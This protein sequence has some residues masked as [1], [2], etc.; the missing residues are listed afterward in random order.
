MEII[1][2]AFVMTVLFTGGSFAVLYFIFYVASNWAKNC[3]LHLF[4]RKKIFEEGAFEYYECPK[5]KIREALHR[6]GYSPLN[7][8]WLN[9]G[10]RE[11]STNGTVDEPLPPQPPP[12][13]VG[14]DTGRIIK[15]FRSK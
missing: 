14:N 15:P 11:I 6:G 3:F 13:Q 4:R 10:L 9:G 7:Q 12:M 1:G 5:C 8:H 2:L